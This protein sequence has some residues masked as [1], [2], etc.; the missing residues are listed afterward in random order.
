MKTIE[1]G[2][3]GGVKDGADG[4][5]MARSSLKIAASSWAGIPASSIFYVHSQH[6]FGHWVSSWCQWEQIGYRRPTYRYRVRP[7]FIL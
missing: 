6:P 2:R 5:L 3:W 7:R 1:D 4:G